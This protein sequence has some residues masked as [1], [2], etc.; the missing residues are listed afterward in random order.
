MT[1]NRAKAAEK[2]KQLAA[3]RQEQKKRAE[4]KEKKKQKADIDDES[5][6]LVP[7]LNTSFK[8]KFTGK[9]DEDLSDVAYDLYV[10]MKTLEIIKE[11]AARMQ[12]VDILEITDPEKYRPKMI[13]YGGYKNFE[14]LDN[15]KQTKQFLRVKDTNS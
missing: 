2:K 9:S 12:V 3:I 4:P 8:S 15:V 13:G 6:L 7:K 1:I 10:E 14:I 11:E 5:D